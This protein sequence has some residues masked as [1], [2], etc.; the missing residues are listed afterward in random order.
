MKGASIVVVLSLVITSTSVFAQSR[1]I[2]SPPGRSAVEV[3]GHYDIREGYVG[4]QWIEISYGRP[5]RRGRDVFGPTG[6]VETLNDGAPVWR[7]GANVS[8]RLMTDVPLLF[9]AT[10]VAP[11]E[12]T[13]FI[14]LQRNPWE[15]IVSTWEAQTTYDYENKNALWGA[16]DYTPD[17][18]VVR[19]PMDVEKLPH[20]FAQLAWQFLDMTETTGGLAIIWEKKMASVS[21]QLGR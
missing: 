11:G 2:A 3:G 1:H 18:D 9:G 8:T 4:G 6:H 12:Y 13:I 19:L 10:T 20:S 17:K 15:L 16:Y 14:D 5:I 21:F 7:A